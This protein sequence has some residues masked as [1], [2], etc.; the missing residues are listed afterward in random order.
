MKITFSAVASTVACV[1]AGAALAASL[2]H[3]GPRGMTGPQGTAGAAGRT[4]NP[5]LSAVTAHLGICWTTTT[6]T[7]DETSWI[8]SVMVQSPQITNG[9]YQC[10]DGETFVP[11]VPQTQQASNG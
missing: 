8:N 11:I 10:P 4:G 6:Q 5:G 7:S 3:T 9:V 1:L 2:T